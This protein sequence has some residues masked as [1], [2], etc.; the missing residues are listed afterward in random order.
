M[1]AHTCKTDEIAVA[2]IK[3]GADVNAKNTAEKSALMEAIERS[4]FMIAR[5]LLLV[6]A[7]SKD[8]LPEDK[9]AEAPRTERRDDDKK[10]DDDTEDIEGYLR[11][12]GLKV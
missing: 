7:D 2:L 11:S 4:H 8:I 3:A 12:F 5:T 10:A 6:G 1:A 9:R